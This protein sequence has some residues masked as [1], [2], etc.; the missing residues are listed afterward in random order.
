MSKTIKKVGIPTSILR[1]ATKNENGLKVIKGTFNGVSVELIQDMEKPFYF[2]TYEL[3]GFVNVQFQNEMLISNEKA[4]SIIWLN[5]KSEYKRF[6]SGAISTLELN[7]LVI[8]KDGS[9]TSK[10]SYA[11]Y[12]NENDYTLEA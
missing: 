7:D 6:K 3:K 9:Y 4:T 12:S 5:N 8:N 2:G 1:G 11:F 10:Y